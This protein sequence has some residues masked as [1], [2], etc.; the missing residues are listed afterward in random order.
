VAF[1][2]SITGI[3]EGDQQYYRENNWCLY[4]FKFC[5]GHGAPGYVPTWFSLKPKDWS[6]NIDIIYQPT[7][8]VFYHKFIQINDN[9]IIRTGTQTEAIPLGTKVKLNT[10]NRLEITERGQGAGPIQVTNKSEAGNVLLGLTGPSEAHVDDNAP[11][12]VF[13]VAPQNTLTMEPIEK[14]LIFLAARDIQQGCVRSS[15]F[16]PGVLIDLS[17]I[18]TADNPTVKLLLNRADNGLKGADTKS[19]KFLEPINS[20]TALAVMGPQR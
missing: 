5:D 10:N 19:A 20:E 1:K 17:K 8:S 2:I 3:K 9:T 11:F 15:T 18:D 7:Y 6:S 13:T 12:A 14:V 4:A 16:A